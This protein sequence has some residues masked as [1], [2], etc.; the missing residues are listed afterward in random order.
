M[1]QILS[2]RSA[3]ALGVSAT[4]FGGAAFAAETQSRKLVV[5]IC[6]GAMDGLSVSPP[7]NDADYLALR[8]PIA[9]TPDKALPLNADFGLH[10]KLANFQ[11]LALAGQARIAP[12]IAIPLRVR[13]HFEA[14]DDLETGGAAL[15]GA[16]TGWLNRTVS[17]LG[18][19]R[20]ARA[21]AVAP[22]APLI[23]RG[24]AS[25]DTWSPGGKF[26]PS[27]NRL[28]TIL[29][30]LYQQD[31]VL[32]PALAKG[33]AVEAEANMVNGASAPLKANDVKDFATGA[34]RFLSNPNGPAIAV[35][36]VDGFD[37][38]ANQGA[39]EGQL[40]NRLSSLDQVIGG[41]QQGLGEDWGRT[42][43]IAV[44]EF[45]RTARI[46]GTHGTDH[47]TASTMLLAGGALKPGGII[48][49]WPGL[50]P[51]KLFENR[52]TAPT[53]DVRQ[54][55]KGVLIDHLGL[56]RRKAD[57]QVFPDSSDARPIMGLV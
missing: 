29:Q 40:A 49:D 6:R 54:V 26:N 34:A 15:Y 19:S 43:V 5:I 50:A 42:I 51:Q 1:T 35:I 13:S 41:L 21:L 4:F 46:N 33:M 8:G 39:A 47:G 52:D 17:A 20:P 36:S 28:T 11:K 12:A 37:T 44:T 24:P 48:G 2:R 56:D 10:P 22:S 14:Q 38:H 27:A 18:S 7:A 25:T 57:T 9:I 55:F 16:S 32:G 45:G 3:M 30:D 23:L 53:L 31:P